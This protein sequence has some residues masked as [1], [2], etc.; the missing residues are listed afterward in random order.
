MTVALPMARWQELGVRLTNGA[1][2]PKTELTA[3]LVSGSSRHFL[4]YDNYDA[5]LEYNCAHSYAISRGA[6]GQIASAYR[7]DG[8]CRRGP[9]FAWSCW[10]LTDTLWLILNSMIAA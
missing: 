7:R 6:A 3:S 2:L 9:P 4:V 1:A 10:R 8:R 5:L